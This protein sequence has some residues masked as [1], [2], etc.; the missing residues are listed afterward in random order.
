MRSDVAML[1]GA[2]LQE[3]FDHRL[4]PSR[5]MGLRLVQQ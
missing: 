5:M 4:S 2:I 1:E 3:V